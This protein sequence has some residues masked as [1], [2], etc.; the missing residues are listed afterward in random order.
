LETS[1]QRV[2]HLSRTVWNNLF[3]LVRPFSKVELYALS[4]CPQGTKNEIAVVL[5]VA[6]LFA[7][8]AIGYFGGTSFQTTV[9]KT[10]TVSQGSGLEACTVTRYNVWSIE[11][12]ANSTTVGGTS[13][14]SQAVTT[15]QTTGYPSS[16]TNTY[17]GT[18]TGA[19]ASWNGTTCNSGGQSTSGSTQTCTLPGQ[20]LGAYVRILNASNSSPIAGAMVTATRNMTTSCGDSSESF[21]TIRYTFTTN[22]TEW[23]PLSVL[24]GGTWQITVAYLDHEYAFVMLLGLS[25]YNCGTLYLPSGQANVTTS[26]QTS[27]TTS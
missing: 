11:S 6:A 17:T 19:I 10:Y 14:E 26:T 22:S 21:V 2:E 4:T 20:P 15:F 9:T 16:T 13:T 23:Y 1:P 3:L 5:I 24:N 12:V 7:G 8:A 25:V 18:L 27:C